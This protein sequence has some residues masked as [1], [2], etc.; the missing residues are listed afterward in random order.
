MRFC[1]SPLASA[2][3]MDIPIFV[4]DGPSIAKIIREHHAKWKIRQANAA[5]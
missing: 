5:R 2:P 3:D 4:E 1:F